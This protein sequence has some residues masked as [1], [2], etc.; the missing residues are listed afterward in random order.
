MKRIIVFIGF[1]VFLTVSAS[2]WSHARVVRSDTGVIEINRLHIKVPNTNAVIRFVKHDFLPSFLRNKALSVFLTKQLRIKGSVLYQFHYQY[3]GVPVRGFWTTVVTHNNVIEQVY[4]GMESF[5]VDL[6]HLISKSA[7]ITQAARYQYTR[8]TRLPHATAELIITKVAGAWVPV[9]RVAFQPLA[10][11]DRRFHLIHAVT[12]QHLYAGNMVFF[13]DSDTVGDADSEVSDDSDTVGDADSEVPDEDFLPTDMALVYRFNPIRTPEKISVEL[14]HV[15]A[16]DDTELTQS[17]EGFL[18]AERDAEDI[19]RIKAFNCPDKGEKVDIG[20][21]VGV[22]MKILLP[23]CSP[24]QLANKAENG[25]FV[26]NDCRD[27]MEYDR[28]KMTEDNIDRCAEVSMYYH[29]NRIYDFLRGV[30][31]EFSYLSGNTADKPLNVIANFQM[32]EMDQQAI[33]DGSAKLVPMDNAFFTPEDPMFETL[34]ANSGIKGDLLVFGQG[35]K[36]DFGMD[37]DVVYHEFGHAT[38]YTTGLDSAGFV[39]KYGFNNEPG[40]L[41]EGLADSFSMMMTNDPCTG[42]YASQGI[43]DLMALQGKDVDMD[44]DGDFYCM[45]HAENTYKVFDDLNGEVHWDGQPMLASNWTIFQWIKEKKIGGE[46]LNEQRAAFSRLLLKV[47]FSLGT[48]Q[49]TY[50]R[51]GETM[52][53]VVESDKEFAAIKQDVVALIT[54]RGFFSEI[55]S[56]D[57]IPDA[58]IKDFY[59]AQGA[60]ASAGGVSAGSGGITVKEDGKDVQIGTSYLQLKVTVP[61]GK[62]SLKLSGTVAAGGG[63]LIGGG[64]NPDLKLYYRAEKPIEYHLKDDNKMATV[65]KDGMSESGSSSW[66]LE[67]LKPGVYYVQFINS[68]SAGVV[69]GLSVSY[70]TAPP[71]EEDDDADAIPDSSNLEND[72]VPDESSTSSGSG[73]SGILVP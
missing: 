67:H 37:G 33:L 6:S 13:D 29:A 42:E 69:S 35:T 31:S 49:G 47:L 55:R 7:A 72:P 28:K 9:Y 53:S 59:V 57:L 56:R 39:D 65:D 48:A 63:G 61:K 23:I 5:S 36:A 64:G 40:S 14:P 10:L 11:Y 62:D 19:R 44:K 12:G 51:W 32:P 58:K 34:L 50:H 18:T 8:A 24:T 52:K 1:F 70:Y 26:Y 17:E 41:H 73:C 16:L 15:S 27:G 66:S 21:L 60:A 4:N 68:G 30:G 45:R 43:V 38:I 54:E 71:E 3:Q 46:S 25:S 20:P 2:P 22:S